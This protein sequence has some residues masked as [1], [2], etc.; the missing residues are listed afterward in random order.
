MI[1]HLEQIVFPYLRLK[2]AELGLDDDYMGMLIFDEFKAQLTDK[3]KALMAEN[4]CVDVCVPANLTNEFQPLD[5]MVNNMAKKFLNAK[6]SDW[7]ANQI[8]KQLKEGVS[9]HNVKI[10]LTLTHMKPI[11]AMWLIGLYDHLRNQ[12]E[13]IVN[14]FAKAGIDEALTMDMP[15]DD[16][17]SDLM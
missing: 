9:A 6:F 11:H 5:L 3:V 4:H 8:T 2:R 10:D 14:S 12:E 13:V 7:Y 17:F 15:D 16:P 1:E